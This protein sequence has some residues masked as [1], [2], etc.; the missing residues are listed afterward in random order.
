[1]LLLL[2]QEGVGSTN[3]PLTK[4]EIGKAIFTFNKNSGC[5]ET[6]ICLKLSEGQ[7]NSEEFLEQDT[8][9]DKNSEREARHLELFSR[10]R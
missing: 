3:C 2:S 10:G 1:M 9:G 7:H 4:E 6:K 5:R 8:G